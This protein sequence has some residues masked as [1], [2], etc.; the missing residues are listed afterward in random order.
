MRIGEGIS[1]GIGTAVFCLGI[2]GIAVPSARADL[3]HVGV[4]LNGA[5][6]GAA[7][8][9]GV[10]G[11]DYIYPNA[12]EVDYFM[13]S[14]MNTFRVPF[15]WERMQP[16]ASGLL[17]AD[18]LSFMDGFVNYAT[19]KG[20]SVILDPHNFAA[21]YGEVIGAAGSSV[22]IADFSSLWSQLAEHYAS[23]DRVIF[24]LMNEPVG[25]DDG[26]G[27]PGGTT[28]AWLDSANAAIAAIRAT[29]ATNLILVPGNGYTGAGTWFSNF[30]GTPNGDVMGGIL[31]SGDNFAYEVH[32]Y[33][34]ANGSGAA[35]EIFN[36]DPTI[37]VQRLTDFTEWLRENNARGFLGEF[38]AGS[39]A[40]ALETLGLTLDF[41]DAN[42]DA[43]LGWTYWAAGPWINNHG[44]FMSIEPENGIDKPQLAVLE[45][46]LTPV[47]EPG[48]AGLLVV[49]ALAAAGY[50]LTRLRRG[51][52]KAARAK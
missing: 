37:G 21:Y 16:T 34:D 36:D 15:S 41:L 9:P 45:E 25:L 43:W 10:P 13:A 3:R 27:R 31:D 40:L 28:E 18:Q 7:T 33:F 49:G 12:D 8:L 22:T 24:G 17:D 44:D 23:N 32:L 52:A 51:A 29:G 38:G 19:A 4:N 48:T 11:T 50:G 46:H 1:R 5:E 47:P 26:G 6:Y 39:S 2:L 20:A 30:Y 14:G 42:A 35:N